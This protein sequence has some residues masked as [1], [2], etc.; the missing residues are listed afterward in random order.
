MSCLYSKSLSTHT[1][2]AATPD[3]FPNKS[4][5]P[6]KCKSCGKE[7]TPLSPCNQYCSPECSHIGFVSA[8]LKRLFGITWADYQRMLVEQNERCA[9]CGGEGFP[10]DPKRGHKLKL[11]VDHDHATGRVRGLLCHNCNRALGLLHDSVESLQTAITYLKGAT[12]SR[13]A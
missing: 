4:F 9:I 2:F 10:M 8:R 6:K 12:T 5:K 1:E 13:E 3:M 11:F 7:Y